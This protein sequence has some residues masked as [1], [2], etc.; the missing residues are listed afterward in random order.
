MGSAKDNSP[1]ADSDAAPR[2]HPTANPTIAGQVWLARRRASVIPPGMTASELLLRI[3]SLVKPKL[4]HKEWEASR[5]VYMR[6]ANYRP[7][8]LTQNTGLRQRRR[9][10]RPYDP[11]ETFVYR[12]P[13]H[14]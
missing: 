3:R 6:P 1:N 7:Q 12:R 10:K 9:Y 4:G 8:P 14:V 13:T 5:F 11:S 2:P